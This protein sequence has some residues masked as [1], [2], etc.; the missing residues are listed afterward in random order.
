MF[1]PTRTLNS[2]NKQSVADVLK[3]YKTEKANHNSLVVI[4]HH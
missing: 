4:N 1:C 3:N 2:N